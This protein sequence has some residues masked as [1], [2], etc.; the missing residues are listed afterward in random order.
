MRLWT[1]GFLQPPVSSLQ[2]DRDQH[3]CYQAASVQVPRDGDVA[4]E[5]PKNSLRALSEP[6]TA[7]VNK[8]ADPETGHGSHE[9][10][11]SIADSSFPS[12]VADV[13]IP[14]TK[15]SDTLGLHIVHDLKDAAGDIIFVHGLGGSAMRTWSWRRDTAHFWPA[16]FGD[17]EYLQRFRV[18]TFG[19][20]SNFKGSGTNLNITDFAKDLLF[21][22][23]TFSHHDSE[24]IGS[25]PIIFIAHSLG[26]LVVKKAYIIGK[27]DDEYSSILSQIYGI[28]FLATP[29]RGAQYAKM[30]NNILSS[31]PIVAP[32]KA[33]VADLDTH[34]AALQ[35]INEQFRTICH[36]LVL[37]SFFE[38]LKT[39][40]GLTKIL[41]VEKESGILGYPQETSSPLNADHHSIC[42]FQ[43]PEDANYVNV[44]NILRL[45]AGRMA[46]GET[47][48]KSRLS[49]LMCERA[50]FRHHP[51]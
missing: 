32:P 34:S 28:L 19:Y 50:P 30:L 49:P 18:F 22:L 33:Y 11:V 42:K 27:H 44:R 24:S 17:D 16:W 5:R 6:S 47:A 8:L 23:L 37:V 40:F 13:S 7:L 21:Q 10:E 29:H 31:A 48:G 35:D 15:P 26:G 45:W 12:E 2:P 38:T 39:S 43:S 25:R 20:N 4:A 51:R 36:E 14:G 1:A 9:R 3:L 46:A 41:I